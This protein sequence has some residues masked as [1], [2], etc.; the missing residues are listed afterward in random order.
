MNFLKNF[1]SFILPLIAVLITFVAYNILS[2][3]IVEYKANI[4]NDYAI[5]AVA[6]KPINKSDLS[7]LKDVEVKE[8]QRLNRDEIISKIKGELP[9]DSIEILK[10][11]LPFFYKIYLVDYPTT[12]QL[13]SIKEQL[14]KLDYIKRV[15]T[16]SAGHS[17]VYSLLLL[18]EQISK[19]VFL[20]IALF[21]I[22]ILTKQVKIWFIEQDR[23]ITIIQ[24]YG[25]SIFYGAAPIIKLAAISFVVASIVVII[26]EHYILN[27]LDLFLTNEIIDILPPVN[28]IMVNYF[29]IFA[30]SFI[31][32]FISVIGVIVKHKI[33]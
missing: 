18:N 26:F 4:V 5:M 22:F 20:L 33:K 13:Q 1:L 8:L 12:K 11:K 29:Y 14:V 21:T 15:E 31:I 9:Q 23:R 24:Y 19:F 7:F 10:Q 25:G 17:K 30:I 16:F 3:I 2:N 6:K 27:N 32:S 28:T